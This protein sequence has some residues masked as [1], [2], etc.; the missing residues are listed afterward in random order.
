L[1]GLIV[2]AVQCAYATSELLI[3]REISRALLGIRA[4][5]ATLLTVATGLVG[6]FYV[7]FGGYLAVFRTDI[8]QFALVTGMA[9]ALGIYAITA[10]FS[11][12]LISGFWP[13]AGYWDLPLT[14]A[15][16]GVW[17]HGYQFAIGAV[18][19]F[20]FLIASPDAWKRVFIV[21]RLR[22][23]TLPRFLIFV[24]VGIMPFVMLL[25]V[26]IHI[27]PVPDGVVDARQVFSGFTANDTLFVVGA[28]G[29]I[30]CFLSSFDS[31][32]LASVH[33]GLAVQ[34]KQRRRVASEQ[35]RFYWLMTTAL[36]AIFFLFE[37]LSSVGNPYLLA[38][39]LLGPYAIVSGIMV[40]TGASPGRL[41]NNGVLWI[42]VLAFV[43]WFIYFISI[44]GLPRIPTTYQINTVPGGVAV[45]IIVA[46]ACWL[47][48]ILP[49]RR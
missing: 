8:L 13:R 47:L 42:L 27:A 10:E 46:L 34:R 7:L 19:G 21:M 41:P 26:T 17:R 29:L 39:L 44:V 25:P 43:G 38:N 4:D 2:A 15:A 9:I 23:N 33:V 45:F 24:C 22:R 32:L 14:G 36:I 11:S 18:M 12:V 16:V 3:L 30:A 35:A 28:L 40:G 5:H 37:G 31:A 48:S 20:G 1:F 6:Y 49:V